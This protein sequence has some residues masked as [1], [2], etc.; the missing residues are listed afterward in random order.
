MIRHLPRHAAHTPTISQHTQT[1]PCSCHQSSPDP[2][3]PERSGA[4]GLGGVATP[5]MLSSLKNLLS[6][7]TVILASASPRRQ[8]LLQNIV[9]VCVCKNNSLQ[10]RRAAQ[11]HSLLIYSYRTSL[12]KWFHLSLKKLLIRPPSFSHGGKCTMYPPPP[13][14]TDISCP[15]MQKRPQE[16]KLWK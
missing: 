13:V 6:G 8:Q 10:R 11:E 15:G 16:V 5:N 12:W 2:T 3:H 9:C 14:K 7:K 4:T 1:Q